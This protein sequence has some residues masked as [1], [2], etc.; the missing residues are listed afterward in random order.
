M[1][2]VAAL[3]AAGASGNPSTLSVTVD[4]QLPSDFARRQMTR[5]C[6][7]VGEMSR[8]KRCNEICDM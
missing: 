6:L 3:K 7:R 2:L 5:L 1:A 8:E 4:G